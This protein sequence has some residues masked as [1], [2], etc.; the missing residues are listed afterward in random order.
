MQQ[1]IRTTS[2]PSTTLSIS[3]SCSELLPATSPMEVSTRVS[4][5]ETRML[6]LS[7]STKAYLRMVG[8]DGVSVS[9]DCTPPLPKTYVSR[10]KG[11]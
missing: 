1:Y 8:G 3:K 5:V 6:A 9:I 11:K 4:K 10:L 7:S 2:A